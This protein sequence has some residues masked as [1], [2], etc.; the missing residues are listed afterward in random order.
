V[1]VQVPADFYYEHLNS[2]HEREGFTCSEELPLEKY[3]R[4]QA[5]QDLKRKLAAAFILTCDGRTIAGYYTL[6]Q[7]SV[8]LDDIPPE[9]SKKL[10]RC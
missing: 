1:L 2:Q 8:K 10:P 7:F 6:S 9:T 3:L 4:I 5:S